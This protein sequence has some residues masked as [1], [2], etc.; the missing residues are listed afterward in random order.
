MRLAGTAMRR[1]LVTRT[2]QSPAPGSTSLTWSAEWASSTTISSRCLA[3]SERNSAARSASEAGMS[4]PA[5]PRSRRNV[6]SRSRA[7]TAAPPLLPAA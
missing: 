5:V 6:P 3:Q 1:R 2:A 7:G 4:A